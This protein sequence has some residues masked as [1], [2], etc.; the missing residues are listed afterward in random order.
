[1]KIVISSLFAVQSSYWPNWD[2][3]P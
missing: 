3:S 1:M 2:L